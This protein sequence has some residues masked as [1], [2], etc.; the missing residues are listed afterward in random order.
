MKDLLGR[1]SEQHLN[2]ALEGKDEYERGFLRLKKPEGEKRRVLIGVYG[3]TQVGKTTLIL[4]LLGIKENRII[5]LSSALR[6]KRQMGNSA[7]VT[8]SIY[9]RSRMKTLY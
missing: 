3:P 9:Q 5:E 1:L 7:T 8:T 2:W 6:G 4:K